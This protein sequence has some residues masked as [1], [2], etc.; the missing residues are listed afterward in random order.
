[1]A[2]RGSN[3]SIFPPSSSS[4]SIATA[5]TKPHL[6]LKV[7]LNGNNYEKGILASYNSTTGTIEIK[8]LGDEKTTNEDWTYLIRK[9]VYKLK[10]DVRTR[11]LNYR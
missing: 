5:D 2:T 4:S 8:H 10:S 11:V 3:L 1:V 9:A 7:Y 6:F